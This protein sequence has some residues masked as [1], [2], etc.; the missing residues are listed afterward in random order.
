MIDRQRQT[1]DERKIAK[2][3]ILAVQADYC[4]GLAC[5][6]TF[7]QSGAPYARTYEQSYL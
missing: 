1:D 3:K 2:R 6:Q 4:V 5:F 7:E